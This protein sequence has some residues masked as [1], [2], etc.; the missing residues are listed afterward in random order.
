MGRIEIW[1]IDHIS[2]D[3]IRALKARGITDEQST[4][5]V[6]EQIGHY[7]SL[8]SISHSTSRVSKPWSGELQEKANR[9][10]SQNASSPQI[11]LLHKCW[12]L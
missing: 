8:P 3:V 12:N 1:C 4:L 2:K 10:S 5:L 9:S 6:F 7:S 11:A